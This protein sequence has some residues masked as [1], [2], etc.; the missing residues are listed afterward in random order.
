MDR[1]RPRKRSEGR[2]NTANSKNDSKPPISAERKAFEELPK[3]WRP[4]EVSEHIN[5]Q[6]LA[7][8]RKQAIMQVERFEVLRPE[9]VEALSK[10]RQA[11]CSRS[12]TR[13]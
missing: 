10:V 1:G 3:G 12:T 2:N 11:A 8:L 13:H 9:D 6:D 7:S 5:T 4:R